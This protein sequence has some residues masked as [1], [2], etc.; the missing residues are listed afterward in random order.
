MILVNN[1]CTDQSWEIALK[2]QEDYRSKME[3]ILLTEL[4]PGK[5]FALEKAQ[6]H[7]KGEWAVFCDAD[8]WY[9]AHYLSLVERLAQNSRETV[10][11]IMALDLPDIPECRD[12]R[13]KIWF[14]Q[15]ASVLFHNKCHTGGFGQCFKISALKKCGGFDSKKWGFVL[16]DHEIMF[17]LLQWG[18][19][20]YHKDLWCI[21]SQR[22]GSRIRVRWNT[23]EQI[24]YFVHPF[25]MGN[26]FFYRYL[27]SKFLQRKLA[28]RNLRQQPWTVAPVSEAS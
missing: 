13:F 28:H 6:Q 14:K 26:W 16:M 1:A 7:L 2:F 24:L 4:R 21:P 22:R 19:S 10:V 8:T 9:P 12:S 27:R 15:V 17:R 20:V 25:P 11:S 23:W 3:I 18:R 5:I